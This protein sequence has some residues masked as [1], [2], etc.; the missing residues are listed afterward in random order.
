MQAPGVVMGHRAQGLLNFRPCVSSASLLWAAWLRPKQASDQKVRR[1]ESSLISYFHVI[2]GS[3]N[4][5]GSDIFAPCVV[6]YDCAAENFF[7]YDR[8]AASGR[9]RCRRSVVKSHQ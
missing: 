8:L 6:A 7:A 9:T 3:N 4:L 2:S 5:Q 1:L